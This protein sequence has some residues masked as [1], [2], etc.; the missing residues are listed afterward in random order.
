MENIGSKRSNHGGLYGDFFAKRSKMARF[1][2]VNPIE[3]T[4]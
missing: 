2:G 4:D 1:G 3:T